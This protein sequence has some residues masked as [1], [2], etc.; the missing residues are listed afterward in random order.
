MKTI[1]IVIDPIIT[2]ENSW[3]IHL[4]SIL[5]GYIESIDLQG[6]AIEE[7]QNLS[8]IQSYFR[9]KQIKN[10]DK[11]IFPNSWTSMINYVKHWSELYKIDVEMIGFWSHGCYIGSDPEWRPHWDRNWRKVY[12]RSHFRCLDKSYFINEYQKEQF[13]IYVSKRV[14]PD[15][16]HITPFPLEYLNMELASYK[17]MY[18][19][20]NMIVFPWHNYT[21]MDVSIVTDFVRVFNDYQVVFAQKNFTISRKQ[22]L[23]QLAKA[24]VAFLPY[25]SPNIGKEI[26]ECL[27]VN[28][29]PL[30]PDLDGLREFVPEEFRYPVEWTDNIFNYATHA[31]KLTDRIFDLINNYHS[32]KRLIEDQIH[33]SYEHY[34]DSE[35]IIEIIFDKNERI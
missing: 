13:R 8:I 30:V 20:Q 17:E 34:Y 6:V 26:Y 7:I 28:T 19:K 35:K 16:L 9:N 32:Y 10:G 27:L 22:L 14:F 11:F 29:I 3:E 12:E 31:T 15:R 25:Q 18:Y 21:P 1:Y 4:S 24:K 2:N 33:Y 23:T 5:Q